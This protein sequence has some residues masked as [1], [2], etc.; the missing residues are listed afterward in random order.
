MFVFIKRKFNS[1]G[2]WRKWILLF[3]FKIFLC[4]QSS[5]FLSR[6]R[7]KFTELIFHEILHCVL[8]RLRC[9]LKILPQNVPFSPLSSS[10]VLQSKHLESL[11]YLF[12]LNYRENR[13][14]TFRFQLYF[15]FFY[16]LVYLID[17]QEVWETLQ[18]NFFPSKSH[19]WNIKYLICNHMLNVMTNKKV[20]RICS[21]SASPTTSW[22]FMTLFAE[23]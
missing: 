16:V 17:Y 8:M 15:K 3:F 5:C 22:N 18:W 14:E 19:K 11:N 10:S 4:R 7:R 23:N 13:V 2:Y 6:L 9:L 21:A 12:I 1:V 20:D